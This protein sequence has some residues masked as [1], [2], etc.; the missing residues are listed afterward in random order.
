MAAKGSVCLDGVSLAVNDVE[1]DRFTVCIIP[2]TQEITTL[3]VLESGRQVNIEVD[4]IARY[5]E[6]LLGAGKI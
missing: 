6:R 5:L 1:G 4:L 3:G 2:H